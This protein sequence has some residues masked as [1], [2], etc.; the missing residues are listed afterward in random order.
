MFG[1]IQ[2]QAGR[3]SSLPAVNCGVT[4]TCIKPGGAK[5]GSQT[6]QFTQ[7]G[8]TDAQMQAAELDL[9]TFKCCE[10]IKFSTK[11]PKAP[12]GKSVATV[13]DTLSMYVTAKHTLTGLGSGGQQF[14]GCS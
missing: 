7:G 10:S 11:A 5:G 3:S 9:D 6:L 4:L 14:C 13:I 12:S 8:V 1:C 2:D